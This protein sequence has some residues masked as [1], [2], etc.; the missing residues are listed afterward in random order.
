M[1]VLAERIAGNEQLDEALVR[2]L[3]RLRGTVDDAWDWIHQTAQDRWTADMQ[4]AYHGRVNN[5][6]DDVVS[7]YM[8]RLDDLGDLMRREISS[9]QTD[10]DNLNV[11]LNRYLGD[12]P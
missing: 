3:D 12:R 1:T 6:F 4:T 2:D 5:R 7:D 11:E 10:I 8:G 9:L